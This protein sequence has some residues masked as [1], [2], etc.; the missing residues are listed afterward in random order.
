M[1]IKKINHAIFALLCV[2]AITLY[3]CKKS[4]PA[5]TRA[6]LIVNTFSG[7]KVEYSNDVNTG[8]VDLTN[9]S[10][11]TVQFNF[12]ANGT[13]TRKVNNNT[14]TGTWTLSAD[15]NILILG[16]QLDAIDNLSGPAETHTVLTLDEHTLI[17]LYGSPS[18]YSA[19]NNGNG[20]HYVRQTY[21]R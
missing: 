3:S 17:L 18:N 14:Y 16:A 11:P 13:F 7:N 15:G 2:V 12:S 10:Y 9:L 4:T 8:W 1:N 6:Q 20:Y 21:T 5:Q 19:A